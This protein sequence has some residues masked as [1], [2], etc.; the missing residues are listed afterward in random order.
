V[1]VGFGTDE[2]GTNFYTIRNSWSTYWG[3]EGYV[4]IA[5]GELDCSVT[6]EAGYPE[7]ARATATVVAV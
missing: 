3:D 2:H 7:L 4:K 1:L 6:D 5:R